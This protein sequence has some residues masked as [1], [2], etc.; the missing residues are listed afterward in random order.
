MDTERSAPLEQLWRAICRERSNKYLAAKPASLE[1]TLPLSGEYCG[2]HVLDSFLALFL[3]VRALLKSRLFG[4][5]QTRTRLT[6]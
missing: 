6:A 4:D 5:W 2:I 1:A 3:M